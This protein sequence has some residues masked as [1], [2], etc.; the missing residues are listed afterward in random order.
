MVSEIRLTSEQKA[1][2][3]HPSTKHARVL[4][5]PGTG[6]SFTVVMLLQQWLRSGGPSRIKLLT[7]TR[8][9]TAEL[10]AKVSSDPSIEETHP[11]TIH[12]FALRILLRNP[13]ISGLPEPIRIADT[14]EA[15]IIVNVSLSRLLNMRKKELESLVRW[16][17]SRWESLEE[18][19]TEILQE[20][21]SRFLGFWNEHRTVD[22]C[23]RASYA[24]AVAAGNRL[25]RVIQKAGFR[26]QSER[27]Q[28]SPSRNTKA[29]S[30]LF[31]SGSIGGCGFR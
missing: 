24:I 3:R 15:D 23:H 8:A 30:C 9:A 5:G 4:A 26:A 20:V 21:R 18:G 31:W 28:H 10:S 11:S 27:K 29:R 12:S 17:S 2:L 22:V 1:I 7:F 16:M 25:V 14:W 13:G 6:K 19:R